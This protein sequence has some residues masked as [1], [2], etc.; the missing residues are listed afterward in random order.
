LSSIVFTLLFSPFT[1]SSPRACA[2]SKRDLPLKVTDAPR[3]MGVADLLGLDQLDKSQG[4]YR[5]PRREHGQ[6]RQD[7]ERNLKHCP[8]GR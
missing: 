6:H 4:A 5:D 2:C 8:A 1:T 7:A 3:Q